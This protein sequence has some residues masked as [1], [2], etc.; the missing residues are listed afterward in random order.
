MIR[1]RGIKALVT[2]KG[3]SETKQEVKEGAK[4]GELEENKTDD[5]D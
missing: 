2:N 1:H 4:G 3:T 5:E